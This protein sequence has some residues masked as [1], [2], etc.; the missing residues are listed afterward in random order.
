MAAG[1]FGLFAVEDQGLKGMLAFLAD[2]FVERHTV[3]LLAFVGQDSNPACSTWQDRNPAPQG[4]SPP[5][6]DGLARTQE[7]LPFVIGQSF[8][9]Y[10]RDLLQDGIHLRFELFVAR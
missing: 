8:H 6:L 10:P 1:A 9:A 3:C 2:I 4:L 5:S 7:Q